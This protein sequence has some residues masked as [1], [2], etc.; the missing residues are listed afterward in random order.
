MKIKLL[1]SALVAGFSNTVPSGS[2][3]ESKDEAH[4]AEYKALIG[5]GYAE[6]TN[7][8]VTDVAAIHAK[9]PGG[10][11]PPISGIVDADDSG[12][13]V[14]LDSILAGNVAD[15]T[16]SLDGLDKKQLRRLAKLEAKGKDRQGVATAIEDAIAAAE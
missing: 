10:N 5:V 4:I 13:D 1:T 8:A 7:E 6:E 9:I 3:I 11:T 2:V 14:D 15:V 16:A 12:D